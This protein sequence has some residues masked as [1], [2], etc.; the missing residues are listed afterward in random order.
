[1]SI[2]VYIYLG[3]VYIEKWVFPDEAMQPAEIITNGNV[4]ETEMQQLD[5]QLAQLTT[6]SDSEEEETIPRFAT[7]HFID[8]ATGTTGI[9]PFEEP[10]LPINEGLPREREVQWHPSIRNIPM[11]SL[12]YMTP[13]IVQRFIIYPEDTDEDE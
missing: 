4:T 8:H 6:E 3:I 2:Y 10:S 7:I 9:V 5:R 11:D 12:R 1:M 13:E